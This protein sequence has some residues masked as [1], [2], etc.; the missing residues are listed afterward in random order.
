MI[1]QWYIE[2]W[3]LTVNCNAVSLGHLLYNTIRYAY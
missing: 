2:T 3:Q 1:M